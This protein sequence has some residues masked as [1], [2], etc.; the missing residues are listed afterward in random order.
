MR[1]DII[2]ELK[3][4]ELKFLCW[5]QMGS[6]LSGRSRGEALD[7][8]LR[9]YGA[10]F[11]KDERV[12]HTSFFPESELGPLSLRFVALLLRLQD[13]AL[14][15]PHVVRSTFRED[16]LAAIREKFV[17]IASVEEGAPISNALA[18]Y[19][20]DCVISRSNVPPLAVY[21]GVSEE[22]AL[23]ALVLKMELEKYRGEKN[24]VVLILEKAKD[25][26]LRESTYALAQSRLDDVL[27][28]RGVE[29]DAMQAL[30]HDFLNYGQLLG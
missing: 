7:F 11:D 20:A 14:L 3:T 24:R 19:N 26:P 1:R 4:T 21:L 16:V 17:G 9:E 29:A 6:Y 8:L 23:Q 25:N 22:R 2:G 28:F 12:I 15:S 27:S 18:A 5:K 13:L 30:H 10:K